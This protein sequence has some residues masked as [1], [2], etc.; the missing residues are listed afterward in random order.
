M[1]NNP[2]AASL[3]CFLHIYPVQA[4]PNY[5]TTKQT[6][7]PHIWDLYL[8]LHLPR[9]PVQSTRQ[10]RNHHLRRGSDQIRSD[11]AKKTNGEESVG[12][13]LLESLDMW[14]RL[15]WTGGGARATAGLS[16]CLGC[17]SQAERRIWIIY[18]YLC[19]G[20]ARSLARR[21]V[22][23]FVSATREG[24]VRSWQRSQPEIARA[25]EVSRKRKG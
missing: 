4:R 2:F 20:F 14:T 11:L 24:K 10:R 1:V 21:V 16:V 15:H 7:T 17:G 9:R 6:N 3:E 22:L 12:S 13:L 18:L 8:H 5:Q 23:S 25:F 19:G